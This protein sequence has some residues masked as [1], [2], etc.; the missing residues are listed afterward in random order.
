MWII[1]SIAVGG[2]LLAGAAW[3]LCF[4]YVALGDSLAAGVGSFTFFGYVPRLSF[5]LVRHAKRIV[6]TSNHGRFGMTSGQLMEAL[7]TNERLRRSVRRADLLTLNIGGNDVLGCRYQYACME[8]A[9]PRLRE[10]WEAILRE[11][12]GLN[13]KAPLYTMNLYNPVPLGDIRRE[14]VEYYLSQVNAILTNPEVAQRY[15]VTG[16]A[17]VH[18]AFVGSECVYSWY[19]TLGDVHPTDA[20]YGVIAEAF[21]RV[22]KEA[23]GFS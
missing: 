16:I 5:F 7:R 11:V 1:A 23:R 22:V 14:P 2:A 17:D 21:T 10:N 19:C 15:S 13:P 3:A 9:I 18:A 6:V 12:R 8:E 20:G 4:R